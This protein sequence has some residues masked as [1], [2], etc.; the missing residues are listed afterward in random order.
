[1]ARE[2]VVRVRLTDKELER[3]KAE[4]ERLDIAVSEVIRK[5]LDQTLKFDAELQAS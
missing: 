5:S 1:M 2:N 4:A 3:L